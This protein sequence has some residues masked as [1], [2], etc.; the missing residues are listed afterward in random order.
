YS[1]EE[2]N[3]PIIVLAIGITLALHNSLVSQY[4]LG[5]DLHT[6]YYLAETVIRKGFWDITI[7]DPYNSLLSVV[8]FAPL[9]ETLTPLNLSYTF[10][11]VYPLVY[12]FTTLSIYYISLK[13]LEKKAALL[14]TCLFIFISPYYMINISTARQQISMLFLSLIIMHMVRDKPMQSSVISILCVSIIVSH[15]ATAILG[16]IFIIGGVIL[17]HIVSYI[18]GEDHHHTIPLR[19][20][21]LLGV[22]SI[23]WFSNTSSGIFFTDMVF[24]LYTIS[25]NLLNPG[26]SSSL[27]AVSGSSSNVIETVN[28][29]ILMLI[30]LIIGIGVLAKTIQ[31]LLLEDSKNDTFIATSVSACA[32][33]AITTVT[34]YFGLEVTRLASITLIILAPFSQVG[35]NRI[36]KTLS[37]DRVADA[38][39]LFSIFLVIVL[40]LNSGMASDMTGMNPSSPSM[41]GDT[42]HNQNLDEKFEFYNYYTSPVANVYTSK[43]IRD[44]ADLRSHRIYLSGLSYSTLI[45]YGRVRDASTWFG[46]T[47]VSSPLYLSIGDFQYGSY[48]YISYVNKRENLISVRGFDKKTRLYEFDEV[49]P[50]LVSTN[51]VY[52]NGNS[53]VRKV[54][55]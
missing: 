22:F 28:K 47:S 43:W 37:L 23:F 5:R 11:L 39:S 35:F 25:T 21:A 42:I 52:T 29:A 26:T 53:S 4:I 54:R 38:K 30:L 1:S 32:F 10:K 44:H 19:V 14:S 16:G 55:K 40:I 6:E 49:R 31:Y 51:T 8:S 20:L 36:S 45:S 33:L 7:A 48:I 3:I 2:F 27:G 46:E 15:Y 12:S 17:Y 34:P 50:G 18:K 13:I 24:R 41:S 9:I